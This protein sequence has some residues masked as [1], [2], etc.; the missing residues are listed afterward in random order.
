MA[1]YLSVSDGDWIS[2]QAIPSVSLGAA[3]LLAWRSLRASPNQHERAW[4]LASQALLGK[5]VQGFH[6]QAGICLLRK[7]LGCF[8]L[9]LPMSFSLLS[10]HFRQHILSSRLGE[11]TVLRQNRQLKALWRADAGR[12]IVAWLR[13]KKNN[14]HIGFHGPYPSVGIFMASMP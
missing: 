9:A 14:N 11:S 13:N 1:V 10:S 5:A 7:A 3:P 12:V 4:Y 2:N 8:Q 6:G